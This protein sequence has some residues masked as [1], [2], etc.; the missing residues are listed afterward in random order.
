M[1]MKESLR[2]HIYN[3][4]SFPGQPCGDEAIAIGTQTVAAELPPG[5]A[6]I[7]PPRAR[8]GIAYITGHFYESSRLLMHEDWSALSQDMDGHLVVAASVPDGVLYIEGKDRADLAALARLAEATAKN[9]PA[10][11]LDAALALVPDGWEVVS[12]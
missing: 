2:Q 12:A 6:V 4:I 3:R 8:N 7:A 9:D 5:S 1:T 10:K 11:D